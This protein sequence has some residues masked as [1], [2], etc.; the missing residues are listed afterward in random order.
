MYFKKYHI[1]FVGIGGI[2]MSGI[3][4]LLLN[5]GYQVS[6][7]DLKATEITERL[8]SLGG[9][10]F[11]GH[12]EDHIQGA[13][14]V[15]TSSAINIENPE[16]YAARKASV[17][18][19]PRAEMLAELMRL[20]YSVAIAGAH[21]KTTTTSLVSSVLG[22]G[23][24]DP[25]VVIGG[26]LKSI[27]SNAVLGRGDYIVA[28]A[29]E[30]DGSF[31]KMSPT[32]AVVTN[33]DRE[34]LDFY[35]DLEDIRKG[36]LSFVH[37]IPFYGLAVLCL[38]NEHVQSIIPD[39]RKRYTTYGLSTQAD[40]QARNIEFKSLQSFYS[41]CQSGKKLGEVLL[42]LPGLH[43]VLNSLAAIAVGLELEIPFGV[44]KT[45]LEK[46]EGVQRRLEIKGEK[47]GVVVV[48]DYGHHPTEIKATLAAAK[49]GWPERRLVVVFQP[50]RFTRTKALFEEFTRAFYESDVLIVLPIYAAG[51][52]PIEGVDSG[53][54]YE[55]IAAHGHREVVF[56]KDFNSAV[57]YL[58]KELK[59][60]DLVLTLGAGDVHMLG[61]EVLKNLDR[62]R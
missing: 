60:G 40:L 57:Q 59:N 20:K 62:H 23:G 43:N 50:H 54:L 37:R 42:N 34:H 11:I 61:M 17:S 9:K 24:L 47:N 39:I 41:V 3:A 7:S 56:K 15:V 8:E 55:S 49:E 12:R 51:E 52:K 25:T 28:E 10:I 48:D 27:G 32:I 16:V 30:S 4:E 2:G 38:D 33:I 26:K 46:H 21:G 22:K 13:D 58:N 19:I 14:V 45:A 18:V 35:K 1:H 53:S 6:G 36:F 5:L 44:I 31:L 29:D